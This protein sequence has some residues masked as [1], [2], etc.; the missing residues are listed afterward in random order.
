MSSV[1]NI[2]KVMN[3]HSLIRVDKAKKKAAK[4]NEVEEK[5]EL[6]ENIKEDIEEDDEIEG[7]NLE[8]DIEEE[9]EVD[10]NLGYAILDL[11]IEN[12]EKENKE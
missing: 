4:F 10:P 12:E 8:E 6:L 2:V 1:K 5:Q 3:F 11:I 9:N 7:E